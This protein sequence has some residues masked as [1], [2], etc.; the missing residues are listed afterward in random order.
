VRK[1]SS[2]YALAAYA[3]SGELLDLLVGSEG[4]LAV[5]IGLEV[6]LAPRPGAT[7]SVLAAFAT[8]E[9]AVAGAASARD[10][11]AS[12]CELLDRTFLDVVRS[13]SRSPALPE[14][15]EAVLLIETEGPDADAAGDAARELSRRLTELGADEVTLA[16]DQEAVRRIWELRH[17]ASPILSRLDPALK[18]MQF[19]EDGAVPPQRLPEY[20]RGVRSVLE[21][22]GVR[23][24]I[25]GH[26]GDAHIHVNPLVDLRRP[27]WR[28]VVRGALDDVTALTSRLGG[29]MAGEHGDGRLRAPLIDRAW[30]YQVAQLFALVKEAF[31]PHAILNPGVKIPLPGQEPIGDVKYDPS[32]PPLPTA[33]RRALDRVERDRA[34]SRFRLD[35]LTETEDDRGEGTH[36]VIVE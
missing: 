7:A 16:L 29:T 17:A 26:A 36:G 35:L 19:I 20:V 24:V 1:E 30:G 18:S 25:F 34:Y 23:G 33:A 5:F 10:A 2:G 32:L 11:G 21:S 8:L 4:T 6:A 22:R 27:D 12:A 15:T 31:D 3:E 9:L 13:G 28:E 14:R